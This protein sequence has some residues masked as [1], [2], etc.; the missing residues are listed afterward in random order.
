MLT[1]PKKKEMLAEIQ[2]V[3]AKKYDKKDVGKKRPPLDQLLL[4]ILWRY[5]RVKSGFRLCKKLRRYFVDWNEMRVSTVSEIA[6]ALSTADWSFECAAH[7]K[8][9]LESLFH[10][11]NV[12]ALDFLE[13][14][15]QA[16]AMTFLR[17]LDNVERDLADELMLFNFDAN[18]LPLTDAG[19]RMS[20][21]MGLI[22]K[23]SATLKNQRA[24]M[25][26]MDKEGYIVFTIF[27]HDHAE[28]IC[29]ENKPK[30]DKCPVDMLCQKNDVNDQE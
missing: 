6:S 28:E 19:A 10:M 17:S 3:V 11:R 5:T 1:E 13:D 24:L 20:F 9:V 4:S 25:D 29:K 27:M 21:R 23:E 30:H 12:V 15:P 18:K 14:F 8:K 7:M 22:E 26:L 16:D 2:K